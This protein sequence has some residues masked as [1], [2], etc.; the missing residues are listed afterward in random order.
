M[1]ELY[2]LN[3]LQAPIQDLLYL[4]IRGGGVSTNMSSSK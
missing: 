2:T 4:P 1:V 3:F